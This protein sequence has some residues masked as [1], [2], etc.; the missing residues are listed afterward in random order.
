MFAIIGGFLND[1]SCR[2]PSG[3]IEVMRCWGSWLVLQPSIVAAL[4]TTVFGGVI[5]G[6]LSSV[7]TRS[8]KRK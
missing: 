1:D 5:I 4:I 8:Q 6:I 7:W 3:W 2:P